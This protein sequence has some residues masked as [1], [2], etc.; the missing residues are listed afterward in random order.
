MPS[1]LPPPSQ[2]EFNV[3]IEA[4]TAKIPLQKVKKGAILLRQGEDSTVTF[5]VARG[6]LRQYYLDGRGREHILGFAPEQWLVSDRESDYF[7]EKS[8][9]CIDALEDSEVYAIPNSTVGSIVASRADFSKINLEMLQKHIRQLQNRI[10]ML[11]SF[12][13]EERYLA[14]MKMYPDV[15]LRVPQSMV[16]SYLGIT[17]ESLSRVRRQLVSRPG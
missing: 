4:L 2:T 11:Q 17:P 14:F 1:A 15:L 9:Y 7:G 5:F 16:A 13:A 12:T 3:F 10:T 8:R 6:L